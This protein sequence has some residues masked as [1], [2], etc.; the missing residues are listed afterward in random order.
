MVVGHLD[1]TRCQLIDVVLLLSMISANSMLKLLGLKSVR[2]V[3][4]RLHVQACMHT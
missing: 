3:G 1:L 4:R 2:G